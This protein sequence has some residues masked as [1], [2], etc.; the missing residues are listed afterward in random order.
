MHYENIQ[1]ANHR[2]N[3]LKSFCNILDAINLSKTLFSQATMFAYDGM[4]L[5]RYAKRHLI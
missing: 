4:N 3:T 1:S 2:I 5:N